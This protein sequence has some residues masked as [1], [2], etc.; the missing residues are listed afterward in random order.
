MPAE[1]KVAVAA[2]VV[3]LALL[4]WR[5]AAIAAAM[6]WPRTPRTPDKFGMPW[7]TETPTRG[8]TPYTGTVPLGEW[9]T[10]PWAYAYDVR[11]PSEVYPWLPPPYRTFEQV[12]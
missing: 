5:H 7:G 12:L 8:Y 4:V 1:T 2:V 11:P 9:G 3:V 6:L 10:K